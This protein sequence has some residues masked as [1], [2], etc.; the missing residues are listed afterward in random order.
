MPRKKYSEA[1]N[2]LKEGKLKSAISKL[3]EAIKIDPQPAKGYYPYLQ[4]G[5]VYLKTGDITTAQ[6]YCTQSQKM[7]AAPSK[8]IDQCLTYIA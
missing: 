5:F 1:Q 4:L 2:Y 3:K 6:K 7:G 8:T